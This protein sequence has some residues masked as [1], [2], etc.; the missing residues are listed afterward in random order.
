MP[1]NKRKG[2]RGKERKDEKNA[3]INRNRKACE[4]VGSASW[5]MMRQLKAE[6]CR[7]EFMDDGSVHILHPQMRPDVGSEQYSKR[8]LWNDKEKGMIVD[9]Y[10]HNFAQELR[11]GDLDGTT[12][13]ADNLIW[14]RN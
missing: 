10:V 11:D 5:Q 3:P 9:N 2:R 6:G 7:I 14:D 12:V 8:E 13:I 4:T 1:T